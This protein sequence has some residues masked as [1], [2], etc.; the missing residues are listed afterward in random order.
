MAKGAFMLRRI[1]FLFGVFS[2]V[3]FLVVFA[4]MAGFVGNI[5][6]PKSIDAPAIVGQPALLAFSINLGLLV[7]FAVPHSVMARPAF[8][9]WWT[10]YVPPVIERTVY[11]FTSNIL[12]IALLL[13]WQPMNT[14]L[15]DVQNPIGR[16]ILWTLFAVGWFLVPLASLMINHFDLFGTRQVWFNLQQKACTSLPF[17]TP[18]L[19]RFVRH[20]LYVGWIIAFW[21]TPTLT[22]GHALFGA[23]L[24]AYIFAAIPF[25]E[26][27]LVAQF[28]DQYLDYRRTV[29]GLVPRWP[30]KPFMTRPR[31]ELFTAETQRS[32][33][34]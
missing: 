14:V 20:P 6:V 19:Y 10:Q 29:G 1:Y 32:R 11:V 5:L 18:M 30:A 28:G 15:Y 26:R 2:H 34:L 7:L 8:K 13:F 21:A 12:M 3:L 31:R 16:A 27:D 25:E 24:T 4:Y 23:V 17:H 22:V 33:S 9:R